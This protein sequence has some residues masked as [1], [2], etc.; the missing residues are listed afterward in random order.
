MEITLNC[1]EY[2]TLSVKDIKYTG[3]CILH[4]NI[5][6]LRKNYDKLTELISSFEFLFDVIC[7]SET[8]LYPN[9]HSCFPISGYNFIADS[10]PSRC[11]GTG[12]YVRSGIAISDVS[13]PSIA[14]SEVV[15]V[16]LAGAD[17]RPVCLTSIYR[18]PASD[19][20]KFLIDFELYLQSRNS[21]NLRHILTGDLNINTQSLGAADY[22]DIISQYNFRSLITL[23]TRITPS[24]STCIDHILINF[25]N[26]EVS[27]GTIKKDTSDHYPIFAV[28][29]GMSTS[30]S[31]KPTKRF[32]RDYSKLN[33]SKLSTPFDKVDWNTLV[34]KA[35]DIDTAYNNF[36][37]QTRKT[38]NEIAPFV[39]IL[40]KKCKS[41]K[42]A[43]IDAGLIK[44]IRKKDRLFNKFKTYP[45]SP[46]LKYR[47]VNQ[48]NKVS[49]LIKK[50]KELYYAQLIDKQDSPRKL[51]NVI[52][53]VCGRKPSTR[54]KINK[55]SSPNNNQLITDQLEIAK[56][57]NLFFTQIGPSLADAFK[58]STAS[59][60]AKL[61][62][63][64]FDIALVDE[65]VVLNELLNINENKAEGLDGIPPKLVK[66]CAH[67]ILKPLTFI[68]NFCIQH[69]VI[70]KEMKC[71]K[72]IPI[73][74]NKGSALSCTN[75]RPISILPIYSKILERIINHQIKLHLKFAQIITPHQFGFQEKKGTQDA[76]ISFNN[77]SFSALDASN[78]IMGIFIDFS[79]AFDT[80]DHSILLQKLEAIN[81]S[82]KTLRLLENYLQNRTQCVMLDESISDPLCI[83]CGVPQG[84]ILG[85]TL[86]LLYIN[87][88]TQRTSILNPILFADDTN[89]FYQSK[90]LNSEIDKINTALKN[91]FSWCSENKLTINS[92]KTSYVIIKNHQNSFKLDTDVVLNDTKLL[93]A[94]TI[95]FLGI[96]IDST[97]NWAPHIANLRNELRQSMGLIYQA[98]SFL[99]KNVLILLYN[100]L[101]N[102]KI[103]YCLEVWGNSP[104]T[105]LNK[106]LVIQKR[107]LRII[108]HKD[109][110]FHTATLF[111]D[112]K[113][114]PINQ[115][116]K[117]KLCVK[118]HLKFYEEVKTNLPYNTRYSA[119]SLDYPKIG[120]T[121]IGR[122]QITYQMSDAWNSL[123]ASLRGIKAPPSFKRTL[124][125]H[126]LDSLT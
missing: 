55:I 57:F 84:S 38:F 39:E 124:K 96:T 4:C 53:E 42:N 74:K 79:K 116:Y 29:H 114:L 8:F 99:P 98:S 51:W 37:E 6:S 110:L 35:N 15:S 50:A 119:L 9:Q 47:Y 66:L 102:S 118:A 125:Q 3:F 83:T 75:Y 112:A 10:R 41:F 54:Q 87:D 59:D 77:S 106:I 23:P 32:K 73:Y 81:F 88:L 64:S 46:I 108:Y 49:S 61:N 122:R 24:S 40:P 90:N 12:V 80:I 95:K 11:G 126:L 120:T 21:K 27:C 103:T 28:F 58:S 67:Y 97:L 20:D 36:C 78:V 86:F 34:Y 117:F 43:W 63:D 123:P 85:P 115:L 104:D 2:T 30:T 14:G 44:E 101:I 19:I 111:Q 33:T 72:V 113:I 69:G 93:E 94:Q 13:T 65:S 70:P 68:I 52:N 45:Y 16:M 60:V 56:T 7:V 107:L 92:T 76:L 121:A 26:Y 109:P 5:R 89:L 100:S 48:R 71:A 17:E 31:E 62:H 18:T 22:L 1:L 82:Y 25:N 105:H 91:V